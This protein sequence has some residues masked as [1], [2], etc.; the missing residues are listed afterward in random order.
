MTEKKVESC[1]FEY[2][3]EAG[4]ISAKSVSLPDTEITFGEK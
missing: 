2:Y 4:G 3:K 1:T